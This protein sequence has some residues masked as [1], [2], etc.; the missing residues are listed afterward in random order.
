MKKHK[1]LLTLII[2]IISTAILAGCG[3]SNNVNPTKIVVDCESTSVIVGNT[4]DINYSISPVNATKTQVSVSVNKPDVVSVSETT[5]NGINGKVTVTALKE[6]AEGALI[7][8][9]IDGTNLMTSTQV[10]V[11]PVPQQLDAPN[12]MYTSFITSS[13]GNKIRF[14][15]VPNAVSYQL[16][17]NGAVYDVADPNPNSPKLDRDVFFDLTAAEVDIVP[18]QGNIVKIKAVADGVNYVDGNFGEEYKFIKLSP[19]TG[20]TLSGGKLTWDNNVNAD[21]YEL[22]INGTQ[23]REY[24]TTNS[25]DLKITTDG[26]YTIRVKASH[27]ITETNADGY[28][29]FAGEYSEPFVVYKLGRPNVQLVNNYAVGGVIG[30]SQIKWP[31]IAGATSYAV[32]VSPA[33][34]L[35]ETDF[36]V[37][38]SD[39]PSIV[40]D[41]NYLTGVKYTFT[42]TPVGDE[43]NSLDPK[44]NTVS[45]TKTEGVSN[46]NIS[47]NKLTFDGVAQS[48]GYELLLSGNSIARGVTSNQTE[49]DIAEM[50]NIKGTYS[51]SVRTLGVI[52]NVLSLA[53][54]EPVDSQI[55]ITKLGNPVVTSVSNTGLV[56]F[57]AEQGAQSYQIYLDDVYLETITTTTYQLDYQ[58]IDIGAHTVKVQAVGNGTGI[59]SSGVEN[60]INYEFTKL[61]QVETV[62][63]NND[64]ISFTNVENA[65]SYS[66][67]IND[68][69]AVLVAAT[70][71]T[72]TYKITENVIDGLNY[73]SVTTVGDNIVNTSSNAK[74]FEFTRLDKPNNMRIENGVLKWSVSDDAYYMVYVGDDED[75]VRVESGIYSSITVTQTDLL[76]K[77][78]ACYKHSGYLS[79]D[80]QTI[81]VNK[82]AK[83]DL[84]TIKVMPK[85]EDNLNPNYKLTWQA[86]PN[87]TGYNIIVADT[88]QND[89]QTEYLGITALS[90]D[91]PNE[92]V[93]DT[94]TIKITALGNSTT[95]GIGYLNSE[96]E[97]FVFNKLAAPTG[98]RINAGKLIWS[99][100]KNPKPAS[101]TIGITYAEQ[102][103]VFVTTTANGIYDLSSYGTESIKVRVRAN[104][105][106][107]TLVTGEYSQV[108]E[109]SKLTA[110]TGFAVTNGVI[111]FDKHA[112]AGV[113]YNVYVNDTLSESAVFTYGE[114]S[115]TVYLPEL[116]AAAQYNITVE[117]VLQG[118]ITSDKTTVLQVVKLNSVEDFTIANNIFTWSAVENAVSYEISCNGVTKSTTTTTFNFS[119][120]NIVDCQVYSFVIRAIG[121]TSAT[122]LGYLNSNASST[123]L[124]VVI[125]PAP[126][127][128]IENSILILTPNENEDLIP[129]N[130][131]IE[132][133]DMDT[134]EVAADLTIGNNELNYDLTKVALLPATYMINVYSVGNNGTIIAHPTPTI[135]ADIRKLDANDAGLKISG[136]VITWTSAI[137]G[138]TFD[139][140]VS[141]GTQMVKKVSDTSDTSVVFNDLE[142]GK[143]YEVA[144]VIKESGA[145]DSDISTA[146]KVTKL[147]DVTGLK[148]INDYGTICFYWNG[149]QINNVAPNPAK[150]A[151]EIVPVEELEPFNGKTDNG[152]V[153][154]LDLEFNYPDVYVANFKIRAIGSVNETEEGYLNGDLS[155]SP[156]KVTKLKP[157]TSV[158]I[159]EDNLLSIDNPNPQAIEI[160]IGFEN[161]ETFEYYECGVP[162]E[163]KT[164]DITNMLDPGIYNLMML[165]VGN[166]DQGVINSDWFIGP[167]IE[168]LAPITSMN[169]INGY[170]NWTSL[171]E[172]VVYEIFADNQKISITVEILPETPEGE[173]PGEEEKN[174]EE[175]A[176]IDEDV[177][178]DT[179]G[180]ETETPVDPENPEQPQPEIITEVHD[181][182]RNL[183]DGR[184]LNP[185]L[186]ANV[187][188][189]IKMRAR[190]LNSTENTLTFLSKFSE[191]YYVNKLLSVD[192]LQ[193]KNNLLTWSKVKNAVGYV[194]KVENA[195]AADIFGGCEYYDD[196]LG[197]IKVNGSAHGEAGFELPT[198]IP[199]GFYKFYVV[200]LG[201]TTTTMDEL[202]YLTGDMSNIAD[203]TILPEPANIHMENGHITWDEV[204]GALNYFITVAEKGT[205]ITT[206]TS[207]YSLARREGLDHLTYGPGSYVVTIQAIGDGVKV[208]KSNPTELSQI[209]VYKPPKVENFKVVDGFVYWEM[210][211]TNELMVALNGNQPFDSVMKQ[212]LLKALNQRENA[213]DPM[214]YYNY[215]FLTNIEATINGVVYTNLKPYTI[216]LSSDLTCL[217]FTLDFN[218]TE[219]GLKNM[220]NIK[221]RYLGS[222]FN[223]EIVIMPDVENNGGGGEEE[224]M[225]A[226]EF[227]NPDDG[228]GE[229]GSPE[230]GEGG[231]EGGEGAPVAISNFV[232]GLYSGEINA[233]KLPAP[234]TPIVDALEN[235][236][237]IMTMIKNDNVY[238]TS[239]A[240]RD[241]FEINYIIT[242]ISQT[243]GE[244]K[245]L[246]I[247]GTNEDY[248]SKDETG[249]IVSRNV[250]KVPV[251]ELNLN[252]GEKY[253]LNVRALG[254]PD[255][256]L[257]TEN[258][259]YLTSNYN[260]QC[261]IQLLEKPTIAMVSGNITVT[262]PIG[263]QVINLRVWDSVTGEVFDINKHNP[264]E[265]IIVENIE[266]SE[267]SIEDQ[268][269]DSIDGY[270]Y[271]YMSNNT[272]YKP[273]RYYVQAIA[274]GDGTTLISSKASDKETVFKTSGVQN[275]TLKEGKFT[276][277]AVDF[278]YSAPGV[279]QRIRALSYKIDVIQSA[280][281]NDEFVEGSDMLLATYILS[282]AEVASSDATRCYFDLPSNS[283]MYPALGEDG[284]VFKYSINVGLSGSSTEAT[285]EDIYAY[286]NGLNVVN[287]D[288]A[289]SGYYAR[290]TQPVELEMVE[291]VLQWKAVNRAVSYEVYML[292]VSYPAEVLEYGIISDGDIRRLNFE[293]FDF[294][295]GKAYSV[296]IRA[297]PGG[298][299][300]EYLNGEYSPEIFVRKLEQPNIRIIDGVIKWNVTEVDLAIATSV[301]ITVTGPAGFTNVDISV[302]VNNVVNGEN[303][304]V[305]WGSD[306]DYP[307]GEYTVSVWFSG[308][309]GLIPTEITDV[310]PEGG[311]ELPGAPEIN[312]GGEEGG[313]EGG[314][315]D[316]IETHDEFGGEAPDGGEGGEGLPPEGEGGEGVEP[317]VPQGPVFD[318]TAYCWFTSDVSTITA[319]KIATLEADRYTEY[320]AESGE[321]INYITVDR[322]DNALYYTFTAVKYDAA[323]EIIKQY[324]TNKFIVTDP[325]QEFIFIDSTKIMYNLAGIARYDEE[326]QGDAVLFGTEFSMYVQAF[327][328][329]AAYNIPGNKYI[330]SNPSNEVAIEI[331]VAPTNVRFEY[332]G[333]IKWDNYSKNTYSR[334][335]VEYEGELGTKIYDIKE[336]NVSEFK[337]KDIGVARVS[338]LSYLIAGHEE[339]LSSYTTMDDKVSYLI[340]GGGNGSVEDPYQI[341]NEEHLQNVRYNMNS[342]YILGSDVSLFANASPE[343]RPQYSDGMVIN[344]IGVEFTGVFDGNNKTIKN[345]NYTDIYA[346]EMAFIHTVAQE[347]VIKDL[348]LTIMGSNI[349]ATNFAGVAIYNYGTIS[350]VKVNAATASNI[351][352]L[353]CWAARTHPLH[354]LPVQV[355]R[356]TIHPR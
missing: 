181:Y 138:A 319:T 260:N 41:E 75:G 56:T 133:V 327:A 199:A 272:K 270:Y 356:S 340:Y 37:L 169:V 330:I 293:G 261:E 336:L 151:Y 57:N 352:S 258:A 115:V 121:S 318:Q 323:G 216:A 63:V 253:F 350:N 174:P 223:S 93:S 232:N 6:D 161:S 234:Q 228:E 23:K 85:G 117:A 209:V 70:D 39:D 101:Y 240:A 135:L 334:V 349:N 103:E 71:E 254:T 45:A 114:Q 343:Q 136:G 208:L 233:Y 333:T 38:A 230:G 55:T 144:I 220:Y 155:T 36:E 167:N 153:N 200:A 224:I 79:S 108:V 290:L 95:S 22:E 64:T 88:L 249:T 298:N 15:A 341:T 217:Q 51:L 314:T 210:P 345:I 339:I 46:F 279:T 188:I 168:V 173:E 347:G 198:T 317:E 203:A 53:N 118:M 145:I 112:V 184:L 124:N 335:R 322:V 252:Q 265:G 164:L 182:F 30:Y 192:D 239:V 176:V 35:G 40:L 237:P 180:S 74:V 266:L 76:V 24:T 78:K 331:P 158:S 285:E 256:D 278:T 159:T 13:E 68:G 300:T 107:E 120:F 248:M 126:E 129:N 82:L 229:G 48:G 157:I 80:Y 310:P 86:V 231:E 5:L 139:I 11:K 156:L 69:A 9:S 283:D 196:T 92:Y 99:Y 29:V 191:E 7:T 269:I 97:T 222:A 130:Y 3:C 94:Y 274:V 257:E 102:A 246:R 73:I 32:S 311:E 205:G 202:G 201:S 100:S 320:D 294:E 132:I 177:K 193:F 42:V 141:N 297:L 344:G 338:V 186:K 241:G 33:N 58:A 49:F 119:E 354:A 47:N 16:D 143:L 305:L 123:S 342:N 275:V 52:T 271:F 105:N 325:T 355:S 106:N 66:I 113:T 312:E 185:Q 321:G 50:F 149:V 315:D 154:L 308:S 189:A 263:A 134:M 152:S 111:T 17:L 287:S 84:S 140:Y 137:L 160:Y 170:L 127:A 242:A 147:P 289:K 236:E 171:G 218:F 89:I 225:L 34:A 307:V 98:V 267:I 255:S 227:E 301:N 243:T 329:N 59:I 166:I 65:L 18:D 172:D 67:K 264:D 235:Y 284:K 296:I 83:V 87:A 299:D 353:K 43:T 26:A 247:D 61:E 268:Y 96:V 8:F 110:V 128:V 292:D 91:I 304:Y 175:P 165:V 104:G 207:Y 291:G 31:K 90:L 109:V 21:R 162:N 277:D 276:W 250:Y 54:S 303:G 2:G 183:D 302:P 178:D 238:F 328:E 206:E 295:T 212:N 60:A 179:N 19:V 306:E 163:T 195:I 281:I 324:T 251:V 316:N 219:D 62:V 20:L 337:L 12:N 197:G 288:T 313:E 77:V 28:Y 351:T 44:S 282:A 4:V 72:I 10:V 131:R 125:A 25:Y 14:R 286:Y 280:Y 214:L 142:K 262:I 194:I 27:N 81:T 226:E 326:H 146:L 244:H 309:N 273:G 221:V 245:T 190:K 116:V 204:D 148:L 1:S 332:P 348:T 346:S 150:F 122:T 187:D 211:F 213:E 259:I 215:E